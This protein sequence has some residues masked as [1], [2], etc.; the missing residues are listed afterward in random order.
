MWGIF[1]YSTFLK[2]ILGNSLKASVL[3]A[4]ILFIRFLFRGRIGAR[5]QY[6]LWF[7]VVIGLIMPWAPE[8]SFS[9]YNLFHPDRYKIPTIVE[10]TPSLNLPGETAPVGEGSSQNKF[11]REVVST[12]NTPINSF[13]TVV[14][15]TPDIVK[16]LG[17]GTGTWS[18]KKIFF[19]LWLII[20]C[21]LAGFTV[22]RNRVFYQK[23]DAKLIT[24]EG[25]ISSLKE[26]KARLKVRKHIPLVQTSKVTSPSL[27]GIFR[28][29][30]LMPEKV[31]EKL[32]LDQLTYVFVHELCHFKRKDVLVNWLIN[33]LVILHWFN[34]VIWYMAYKMREDQ[35][36]ACDAYALSY[37]G[38]DKSNDYGYTLISLLESCTKAR[39]LTGLASL[40]GSKSQLKRRV[41]MLKMLEKAS[42][43]WTL[44]GLVVV[45]AISFTTL[46]NAKTAVSNTPIR[47]STDT[48]ERQKE[49]VT[50]NS[51]QPAKLKSE[52][53]EYARNNRESTYSFSKSEDM[54][55][56]AFGAFLGIWD[57]AS[58]VDKLPIAQKQAA[59]LIPGN[60]IVVKSYDAP[61]TDYYLVPLL[62]ESKFVGPIIFSVTN[63]PGN[64]EKKAELLSGLAYNSD[65]MEFPYRDKLL[66]IDG[67]DAV[68]IIKRT[69]GISEVPTPRLVR[70]GG[71][72][73]MKFPTFDPQQFLWE[74]NFE[75]N[76]RLYVNQQ[77]KLL[78]T[79]IT[80]WYEKYVSPKYDPKEV[81]LEPNK[82]TRDDGWSLNIQSIVFGQS[83]PYDPTLKNASI[84]FTI[85]N[86]TGDDQIFMPKGSIVGITSTGGKTYPI[87][88]GS[89]ELLHIRTQELRFE[90]K[91]YGIKPGLL[92]LASDISVNS[93]ETRFS[94]VTYRDEQGNEFEIPVD[95]TPELKIDP[96]KINGTMEPYK[97]PGKDWSLAITRLEFRHSIDNKFVLAA[98]GI[99]LTSNSGV[100][101]IFSPKGQIL[102]IK[103]TSGKFYPYDGSNSLEQDYA[104][105]LERKKERAK[106]TGQLYQPGLMTLYPEIQINVGEKNV[107]KIIYQDENGKKFD[108]PVSGISPVSR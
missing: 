29:K 96:P 16:I 15:S 79:D 95:L 41:T 84:S 98:L 50:V 103:G 38:N 53:V 64:E 75:G 78:D 104:G 26:I 74:F 88:F 22:F 20:A 4:L 72:E 73:R 71:R 102:G 19:S 34:P 67:S 28:P 66:D 85:Q 25:L 40:S 11:D 33:A 5:V 70:K 51:L 99:T 77:G 42:V 47:N 48:T 87:S 97:I 37:I 10:Q 30:L 60:P 82:L 24:D 36:V 32:S 76:R 92:K 3:A 100:D 62:K 12:R 91:Q 23:L 13:T 35:E 55:S 81:K 65:K 94:K 80:P 21:F 14:N 7:V 54:A 56:I 107:N 2:W 45:I 86:N 46:T 93:A 108:I 58:S 83:F 44:L 68:D 18:I 101:T 9:I 52:L 69:Q 90:Q 31:Q 43:K 89:L 105:L 106:E 61:F 59:E 27:Y 57:R 6:L 39:H 1:D 8:S 17:R 63:T 49:I